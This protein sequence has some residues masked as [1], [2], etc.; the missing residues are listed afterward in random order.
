MEVIAEGL[1]VRNH[2]VSSLASQVSW[3]ENESNVANFSISRIFD[4]R[5]T[6]QLQRRV[7]PEQNLRCILNSSSSCIDEFLDEHLAKDPVCLLPENSAEDDCDSV[8]AC[9]DE[10]GFLITVMNCHNLSSFSNAL[11]CFLRCEFGCL[12]IQLM[13]LIKCMLERCSHRI[14]FHQRYSSNKVVS[15][16]FILRETLQ[17]DLNREIVAAFRR[18]YVWAIFPLQHLLCAILQKLIVAPDL[19]GNKNFGF[20]LGGRD[21]EGYAIEVLRIALSAQIEL[22]HSDNQGEAF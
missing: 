4:T 15:C 12:F 6:L 1:D 7:G 20:R 19:D 18:N 21:M 13:M 8:V 17:V 9:L 3:E 2:L 10:N 14:S 16:L 22:G 11:W 5:Y